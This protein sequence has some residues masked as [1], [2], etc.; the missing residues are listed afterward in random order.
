MYI[1]MYN[2]THINY[3][4]GNKHF[5]YSLSSVAYSTS[6]ET[7]GSWDLFLGLVISIKTMYDETVYYSI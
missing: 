4:N 1:C 6:V 2:T 5:P 3:T 7:T